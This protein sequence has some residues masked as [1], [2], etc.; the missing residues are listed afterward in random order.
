MKIYE[1]LQHIFREKVNIFF[2]G[3]LSISLPIGV[4]LFGSTFSGTRGFIIAYILK[5]IATVIAGVI[6]GCASVG[7]ADLYKWAKEKYF[8]RKQK[9]KQKR[10]RKAA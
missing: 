7:G 8:G 3:F 9:V 4:F 2:K 6:G 5:L 1:W 10:N